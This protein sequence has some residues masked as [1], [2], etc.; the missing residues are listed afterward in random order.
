MT[1]KPIVKKEPRKSFG[2]LDVKRDRFHDEAWAAVEGEYYFD[3]QYGPYSMEITTSVFL[4][5]E[6]QPVLRRRSRFKWL[7]ILIEIMPINKFP[8][9]AWEKWGT[10]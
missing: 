1:S 8:I 10:A 7:T 4:E 5:M 2:F 3:L 9:F 6:K